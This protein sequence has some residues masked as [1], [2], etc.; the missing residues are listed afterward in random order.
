MASWCRGTPKNI[1]D[2]LNA[3]ARKAVESKEVKEKLETFGAET[4]SGTPE[5]MVGFMN[6]ASETWMG[7]IRGAGLK[8]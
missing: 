5:E 8:Q 6:K 1:V 7:I 3:A 2:V 4:F